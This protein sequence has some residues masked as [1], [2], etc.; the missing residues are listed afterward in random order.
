[1]RNFFSTEFIDYPMVKTVIHVILEVKNNLSAY[2]LIYNFY[3]I[4][5]L[6]FISI[7][8]LNF[9]YLIFFYYR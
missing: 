7:N 9:Y 5:V 4:L 1:M 3:L 8:L 2:F 6:N